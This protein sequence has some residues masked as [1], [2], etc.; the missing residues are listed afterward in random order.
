VVPALAEALS[1]ENF[2]IAAASSALS[3]FLRTYLLF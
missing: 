2:C 3:H 1:A